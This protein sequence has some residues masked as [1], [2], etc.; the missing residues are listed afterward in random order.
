MKGKLGPSQRKVLE[1]IRNH[2]HCTARDVGKALYDSTSSCAARG[3]TRRGSREQLTT[4]WATEMVRQ[5]K[6]KGHVWT[7]ST[8]GTILVATPR[9]R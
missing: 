1:Y 7:S 4:H 9:D 6:L 3:S 5:L 2:P 8:T